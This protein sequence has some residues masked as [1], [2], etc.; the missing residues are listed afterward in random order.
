MKLRVC[1]SFPFP[2][3]HSILFTI[4]PIPSFASLN[5]PFA[6]ISFHTRPKPDN[7]RS[8]TNTGPRTTMKSETAPFSPRSK[9]DGTTPLQFSIP[10]TRSPTIWI[11]GPS[12]GLLRRKCRKELGSGNM[13]SGRASRLASRLEVVKWSVSLSPRYSSCADD[14]IP[15]SDHERMVRQK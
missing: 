4:A 3:P 8:T 12:R 1:S 13:G 14:Q 6:T 15:S 2:R 5:T 11:I 10:T 9:P 7:Q